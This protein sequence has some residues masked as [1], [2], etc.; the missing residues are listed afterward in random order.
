MIS[1]KKSYARQ[2]LQL[3][4]TLSLLR[5]DPEN[6][7]GYGWESQLALQNGDGWQLELR[8]APLTDYP[9]SNRKALIPLIED[10]VRF[11]RQTNLSLHNVQ[12][13]L[14]NVQNEQTPLSSTSASSVA[15][16][17][18]PTTPTIEM[19]ATTFSVSEQQSIVHD[20]ETRNTTD[21][22]VPLSESDL[23]DFFLAHSDPF[24]DTISVL[25]Q[26]LADLNDYDDSTENTGGAGSDN[27]LQFS[28]L[29]AGL[30]L[31]DEP[32]E[33]FDEHSYN[34]RSS[35]SDDEHNLLS[36]IAGAST[37]SDYG[38]TNEYE[39]LRNTESPVADLSR[40]I[41]WSSYFADNNETERKPKEESLD[42]SNEEKCNTT[43]FDGRSCSRLKLESEGDDDDRASSSAYGDN[44][45]STSG[46][47]SNVELTEEVIFCL[48]YLF[49]CAQ[50]DIC[51]FPIPVMLN[52]RKFNNHFDADR[53]HFRCLSSQRHFVISTSHFH[54]KEREK[55]N[56]Y[57]FTLVQRK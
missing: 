38:A 24:A 1:L 15:A 52:V 39:Y 41:E 56:A 28:Q 55:E 31:K 44:K 34:V 3:A 11:D 27:R 51:C 35:L 13:Y 18:R 21:F 36:T 46:F 2:L 25:D 37:S 26:N 19:N 20:R 9:Y 32:L 6:Y 4:L 54:S 12:T 30:P 47:G 42:P 22:I 45:S 17:M 8:A 50:I 23:T 7:L 48:C 5:V 10:L 16:P 40:V 53:N 14:L 49:T 33:I 57:K 29:Y 43:H